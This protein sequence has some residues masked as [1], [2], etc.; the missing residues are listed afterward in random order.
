MEKYLQ[1]RGMR[2]IWNSPEW[3]DIRDKKINEVGNKCQW[4]N[5]EETEV[6]A[7]H[8]L[9]PL[10]IRNLKGR[11]AYYLFLSSKG[12]KELPAEKIN[13]CPKC[14]KKRYYERKTKEPKYRCSNCSTNFS[15]PKQV[16][17]WKKIGFTAAYSKFKTEN[18]DII[19]KLY[20]EKKERRLR[21]YVSMNDV[22]ILCKKHHFLAEKGYI[23]CSECGKP[24]K[25]NADRLCFPCL[26]KKGVLKKCPKCGKNWYRPGTY[27]VC[28]DCRLGVSIDYDEKYLDDDDDPWA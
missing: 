19:T 2:K 26:K 14:G 4:P 5:C 3:K 6:L 21:E 18:E 24:I 10:R 22:V 11:M 28:L 20:E 7:P 25:P 27:E 13:V 1:T 15:K 9:K 12:Y 16:E 23:P 17:G 8:H